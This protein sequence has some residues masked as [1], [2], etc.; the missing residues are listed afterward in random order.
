M[1]GISTKML[2]AASAA[3]QKLGKPN[4]TDY[5]SIQSNNS[6]TIDSS[7]EEGDVLVAFFA[8]A[9]ASSITIPS[10]YTPVIATTDFESTGEA[11]VVM[12]K[13]LDG[14]E[15]GTTV[16]SPFSGAGLENTR[17]VI[18][19]SSPETPVSLIVS[20]L[21]QATNTTSTTLTNNIDSEDGPCIVYHGGFQFGSSDD[22]RSTTRS[23]DEA[24]SNGSGGTATSSLFATV[25]GFYTNTSGGSQE[26]TF[27]GSNADFNMVTFLLSLQG[28]ENS[29]VAARYWGIAYT[30]AN[31]FA[32][33]EEVEFF[34]AASP[35]TDATNSAQASTRAFATS[36][37]GGS[38]SADLAFDDDTSTRWASA[39]RTAG[40]IER[41]W[42]DFQSPI[43]IVGASYDDYYGLSNAEVQY[44]DDAVNWTT[45]ASLPVNQG[46]G[47]K[48]SVTFSELYS[49]NTEG[50]DGGLEVLSVTNSDFGTGDFT[51]EAWVYPTDLSNNY[52]AVV[53]HK[54]S[55]G[56]G[57]LYVRGD[58]A[59]TFWE[60]GSILDVGAGTITTNQWYH[61][62]AVRDSGTLTLYIDGTSVG[63]TSYTNSISDTN[64]Y[65]GQN[66][67]ENEEF[68][69]YIY[70]PHVLNSAKYSGNF[71]PN[72]S[73]SLSANSL[74]LLTTDIVSATDEAGNA[75]TNNGATFVEE[76]P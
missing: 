31:S 20:N 64:L 41:I 38:F 58:G 65:A 76:S 52:N 49:F 75:V 67:N 63:S 12:Y 26:V 11:F 50:T 4:V 19:R 48:V 73:Y 8:T 42:W 5:V 46:R 25:G 70:R 36:E 54:W 56:G 6:T 40:S 71:T 23:V 72:E 1:S 15:G 17:V 27:S 10:G 59:V 45:I 74:I 35:T 55:G 68:Q 9:S 32:G 28:I 34:S 57:L 33:S 60:G 2:Q 16:P 14:T 69:G 37:F 51:Y 7:V 62:A 47:V 30:V 21:E 53:G 66:Q 13:V 44:S 22:T 18:D 39:S 29:G 3:G 61:V 24:L 43:Q